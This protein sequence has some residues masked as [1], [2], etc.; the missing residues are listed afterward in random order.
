MSSVKLKKVIITTTLGLAAFSIGGAHA[1]QVSA[2]GAGY[3]A[4]SSANTTGNN[5]TMLD[6]TGGF[7]GG[8]NNVSM[9]WDGT[10]FTS[11]TDYTGPGGATNMTLAS[12]D[13]F[14]GQNWTAHSVQVF[15][16][17]TYTFDPSLGGGVAETGTLTLN[18]GQGQL[19][20]H[21]LFNWGTSQNID[22]AV[23]WDANG[24]FGN[25]PG[26]QTLT[27]TTVWDSV[28]IDGNGDGIP[29]ISMPGG[30]PFAGFN[31]NFNLQGITPTVPAAAPVPVPAAV[32]LLGSGLMGLVGVAR[33]K[34][35][36]A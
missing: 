26:Q 17:G 24:T 3:A 18:V 27:G 28:S 25:N 20:A 8:S 7:V 34:K 16:P 31:A 21:M 14:F 1:A 9:T 13:A 4:E 5:F 22:V 15:A 6:S 30:G 12:P 10:V 23:L 11:S 35:T 32:W 36:A 33:R 2:A 29:G 19:G